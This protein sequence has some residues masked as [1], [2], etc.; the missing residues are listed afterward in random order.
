MAQLLSNPSGTGHLFSRVG[1]RY[2]VAADIIG[3]IIAHWS[4]VIA[5][6]YAKERPDLRVI[7]EA[8][9]TRTAL[10]VVRDGIDPDDEEEIE[11]VIAEYGP[12]AR[13][14]YQL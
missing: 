4:A 5:R 3:A 13:A 14:L 6:E 9:Q 1:V 11:R 12:R 8:K 10:W 7:E 2:E